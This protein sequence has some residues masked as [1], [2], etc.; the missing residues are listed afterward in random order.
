MEENSPARTK[1]GQ[2]LPEATD[3]DGDTL[4][5]RLDG[6]DVGSFD[7]NPDSRQV[8][9]GEGA[10]LDHESKEEHIVELKVSD[11]KNAE[12]GDDGANDRSSVMVT[13]TVLDEDEPPGK[14]SALNVS[15]AD[16]DGDTTL[17]VN[18]TAPDNAGRPDISD[19]DV[20]YRAGG[21]DFTDAD[22]SGTGTS[23]T[24]SGLQS[25]T[26]YQVQVRAK[27]D[28]G[29]GEW[30]DSG[31]GQT[32][33]AT[34]PCTDL[35]IDQDDEK[36]PGATVDLTLRFTPGGCDP[37]G[38]DGD[39]HDE[40]TI[41]L[42]EEI[43]IPS[44]FDED[45]VSLRAAR[46]YE[47][48]WTDVN[49]NDD[50]PHE[51]V[52]PGCGGW[53]SGS[54]DAVCDE[55]GLPVTIVLNNLRLPDVPAD[56]DDP[57]EVTIQWENGPPFRG[58]VAVDA[59]LE[60]DGD[61]EVGYGETIRFEG[62]G[63]SDGLTVDL[64]SISSISNNMDCSTAGGG[65]WTRIGSATVGSN[66][67]FRAD[68]EVG[69]NLFRSA[70]KYWVCARD[71]G[72]VFNITAAA[73]TITAGLEITGS[74]EVSPGGEVILRI[75]GGSGS[76]VESVLVAGQSIS[77]WSQAGDTLRVTLPP[78]HSGRVTIA[79]RLSGSSEPVTVNI[80]IRDAELTV[81]PDRGL[82]LGEQF[83]VNSNNLAGDRVCEVTL[84][85]IRLAFLDD[86]Q[87]DVRSGSGND[88]PEVIRGGRFT[89][90]A[91]LV[92]D[93]GD[94]NSDL[95]NKLLQSDGEEKLEIT[96]SA[97][98]KASATIRVDKPTLTV[99]PDEG[100]V[101]PRD[102]IV[103]RGAELPGG[104]ALLQSSPRHFGNQ[105]PRSGERVHRQQRLL[106]L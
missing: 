46:R 68:V 96:D 67:R 32:G 13:I 28:E 3:P 19:Y 2:P 50:E 90:T 79:A 105:R 31:T 5:Y 94:V 12:G 36:T 83:L 98:V 58:K 106:E 30:S 99:V 97:G 10:T 60:V 56:S 8:L 64:Y 37:T 81:R 24:I 88:C 84:G 41:T 104:P 87:G 91:A 100:E 78:R 44:G 22:Y 49:R 57:Y 101:S 95:I 35:E 29:T 6:T 34:T 25:D 26:Q 9:V 42:S 86:D 45:D 73:V 69:T 93:N 18:W 62:L 77:Q 66:H 43:A 55:T 23:T 80:T 72:G 15:P 53:E 33:S 89:A 54:D 20:Q 71:G 4:E 92:N 27:N 70:G 39:L 7:F 11:L 52:L 40:I 82:G 14:P 102:V 74:S 103:F 48:R 1:I 65:S 21:G 38:D 16:D 61:D 47:L 63:F 51:I 85:G 76:R 17:A 75:V 59:S